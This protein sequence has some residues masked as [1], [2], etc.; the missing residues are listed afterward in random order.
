[1]KLTFTLEFLVKIAVIYSWNPLL[2]KGDKE[3]RTFQKLSHLGIGVRGDQIY[4]NVEIRQLPTSLLLYSFT[5]QLHLLYVCGKSK[6][7]NIRV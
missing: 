4:V 6:V 2:I 1:M 7:S 5:V 3:G